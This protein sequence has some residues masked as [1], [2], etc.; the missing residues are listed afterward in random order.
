MRV[1]ETQL[2]GVGVRHE[3]ETESGR[4]V[5]VIV[6]RDGRREI[7]TYG[8]DDPDACATLFELSA[9]GAR[10]LAELLGASQVSEAVAAV[11]QDIAGLGIEW[12]RLDDGSPA[13]GTTIMSGQFRSKTGA[14]IVAVLRGQDSVPAPEPEFELLAGDTVVAVGTD[15]GLTALRDLLSP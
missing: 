2:P 8:A 1:T 10:T 7:V 14:S 13:V 15:D 9:D 5:G 6:H 11:R 3:F 12:I 4:R